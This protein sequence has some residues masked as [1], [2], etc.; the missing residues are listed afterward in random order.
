MEEN[1]KLPTSMWGKWWEPIRKWF[2][3]G[4]LIYE[5]SL[6]FYAYA[7]SVYHYFLGDQE[8]LVFYIGK[9][10]TRALALFCSIFTFAV[11]TVFLTVPACF[12]LYH[13]FKTENLTGTFY[14]EKLKPIF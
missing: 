6:R 12:M 10:A 4:W 1:N 9:I 8:D 2:Y 3:P 11:C 14:E 13:F 7:I 5:T